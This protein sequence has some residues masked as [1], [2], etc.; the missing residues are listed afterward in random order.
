[1]ESNQLTQFPDLSGNPDLRMVSAQ[2]NQFTGIGPLAWHQEIGTH[3][4]DRIRVEDNLLDLDDCA[5]ITVLK[6]RTDISGAFFSFNPQ[7]G[8]IM[9]CAP[10]TTTQATCKDNEIAHFYL[11]ISGSRNGK[12]VDLTSKRALFGDFI[13]R[14]ILSGSAQGYRGHPPSGRLGR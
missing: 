12:D 10:A 9:D 5:R 7:N 2:D 1:M 4:G 3:S 8:E 6:D 14:G 13:V 11:A